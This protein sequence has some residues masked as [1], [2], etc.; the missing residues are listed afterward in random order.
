MHIYIYIGHTNAHTDSIPHTYSHI[1]VYVCIWIA[2][3][4]A[5]ENKYN[6]NTYEESQI[7]ISTYIY[8]YICICIIDYHCIS[9][10]WCPSTRWCW[11]MLVLILFMMLRISMN[12]LTC[13]SNAL[14][15]TFS[16][17]IFCVILQ[18]SPRP[19]SSPR[20]KAEP[21][22]TPRKLRNHPETTAFHL[23][24]FFRRHFGHVHQHGFVL[25]HSNVTSWNGIHFKEECSK[26]FEV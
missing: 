4:Y 17:A 18:Q 5:N 20:L 25:K 3:V 9:R 19:Q 23:F 14:D 15:K 1:H 8:I 24:H 16:P 22:W 2:Y 10:S 13:R 6:L 7:S 26:M 11:M 21:C 12:H